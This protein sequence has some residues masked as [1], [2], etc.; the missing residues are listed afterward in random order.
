MAKNFDQKLRPV[1]YKMYKHK[2]LWMTASILGLAAGATMITTPALADQPITKGAPTSNGS[3]TM[4]T[5]G[6]QP[7]QQKQIQLRSGG[8]PASPSVPVNGLTPPDETLPT[9]VTN[10]QGL[11]LTVNNRDYRPTSGEGEMVT[12]S[13][14]GTSG[15]QTIAAGDTV[16]IQIDA[17]NYTLPNSY[18]SGI[19][20]TQPVQSIPAEY[21]TTTVSKSSEGYTITD[22]FTKDVIAGTGT[23]E[24]NFSQSFTLT[25]FGILDGWAV[26]YGQDLN[27]W[28]NPLKQI[29]ATVSDGRTISIKF[30]Q[31]LNPYISPYMERLTPK[32]DSGGHGGPALHV[33]QDYS[34]GITINE[35]SGMY[36]DGTFPEGTGQTVHDFNSSINSKGVIT[37]PVDPSFVLNA[38]ATASANANKSCPT[39]VTQAGKGAPVVITVGSSR[40]GND[41][42]ESPYII[43]GKF[44]MPQ[45][46]H[47]KEVDFGT[48]ENPVT[49]H[50]DLLYNLGSLNG[51]TTWRDTILGRNDDSGHPQNDGPVEEDIDG[52]VFGYQPSNELQLDHNT[53]IALNHITFT[54][55]NNQDLKNATVTIDIPDGMDVTSFVIPQIGSLNNFNYKV[56]YFD[57]TSESG[58]LAANT[59]SQTFRAAIKQLQ[60]TL[61]NW[62]IGD[63]T[64]DVSI[65]SSGVYENGLVLNGTIAEKYQNGS[66]VK[67]GDKLTTTLTINA[68]GLDH[69]KTAEDT[70]TL[71]TPSHQTIV[72]ANFEFQQTKSGP[73]YTEAGNLRVN[74]DFAP[75]DQTAVYFVLPSNA[76]YA[77]PTGNGITLLHPS[78][79]Q[80]VIKMTKEAMGAN[81]N[82][83]ICTLE[84]NNAT[85]AIP[86]SERVDVYVVPGDDNDVMAIDGIT[87]LVY[88]D[89]VTDN[90]LPLVENQHNAYLVSYDPLTYTSYYW[91]VAPTNASGVISASTGNQDH[92]LP[93]AQGSSDTHGSKNMAF[94]TSIVNSAMNTLTNIV[95]VT[96]LPDQQFRFNITGPVQ[97]IDASNNSPISG[98]TVLYGT[99]PVALNEGSHPDLT[100]FKTA[101]QVGTDW[102]SIR[103]VAVELPTLATNKAVTVVLNGEDPTLTSDAGKKASLSSITTYNESE[104]GAHSFI[105]EPGGTGSASIVVSGSNTPTE[106]SVHT[107]IHY[108]D[109]TGS[110]KT[111]GY[112]S[113]DGTELTAHMIHE[114]GHNN[115]N[116]PNALWNYTTDPAHYSLAEPIDSTITNA[117]LITGMPTDLYIYLKHSTPTPTP[118]TEKV[119]DTKKITETIH[120]LYRDTGLPAHGDYVTS[121]TFT[122]T[123]TRVIDTGAT[124]W[125]AWDHSSYVFAAITSP[126]LNNGYSPDIAVE[127]EQTVTPDSS[128]IVLTVYYSKSSQPTQQTQQT[129][130]TQP[131]EPTQPTQQTQQSQPSEPTQPTQV[132]TPAEP[133]S[134]VQP[135]TPQQPTQPTSPR[136]QNTE[137]QP[138]QPGQTNPVQ[139][140]T[141]QPG[142]LQPGQPLQPEPVQSNEPSIKTTVNHQTQL[143]QTGNQNVFGLIVLS[144]TTLMSS[145]G[146]AV[147]RMRHH[148]AK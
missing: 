40:S 86:S 136:G 92:N 123:G 84:L 103:A 27:K 102:S 119:S 47:N 16:T 116:F 70:Q 49:I 69:D 15:E 93:V 65:N 95:N 29:T 97:V 141:P 45:P 32:V 91:H 64:P 3:P 122:R 4:T 101:A 19:Q 74:L 143:P 63:G 121:I 98:A 30:N 125:N 48:A 59:P 39:T 44:E 8:D 35:N 133:T 34:W 96:N 71:I 99:Q 105:I 138:T 6:A 61:P 113:A 107:T 72:R 7:A 52:Q 66:D 82:Y 132:T 142:S 134:P 57:G 62:P 17:G 75:N 90:N 106:D 128:D 60:I 26:Q 87:E 79:G 38:N 41:Q 68:T 127:P 2:K 139:P 124:T 89:K 135:T 81:A 100:T 144:I 147:S 36:I 115:D 77:G 1:R 67:V 80:T 148:F 21:G 22:H 14:G 146:L 13:I 58:T 25:P 56:T 73:G 46:D 54:N 42:V 10:E 109:V 37:I 85:P 5:N 31:V 33:N 140:G 43:V 131:T 51:T 88:F 83:G 114:S 137:V 24:Y 111:S 55:N 94:Y 117:K 126:T 12:F 112:S 110:S 104:M 18:N 23:G 120:Y 78:T 145:L 53:Q 129:Q 9:T 28:F 118:T 130:G 11:T 20:G 76:V 50:Q 108:I